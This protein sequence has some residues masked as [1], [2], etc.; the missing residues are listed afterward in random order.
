MDNHV[1]ENTQSLHDPY[2]CNVYIKFG[3]RLRWVIA[4]VTNGRE[5]IEESIWTEKP[6]ASF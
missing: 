4:I 5:G 2:A 6:I 1:E 3:S